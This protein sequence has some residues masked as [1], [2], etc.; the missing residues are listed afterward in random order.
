MKKVCRICNEE[1]DIEYLWI[2]RGTAIC[3][4]CK[5]D[6]TNIQIPLTKTQR[7]RYKQLL[8]NYIK[9]DTIS[10]D[11]P[12]FIM[13]G[14]SPDEL[15]EKIESKFIDNMSWDNYGF[16]GWH[17]D[18]M[19]PLFSAKTEDDLKRLSHYS[20]LQ[21]LWKPTNIKKGFKIIN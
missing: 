12:L 14:C 10:I 2:Q 9:M 20:N 6:Q 16:N 17:I 7:H 11:D 21:P 18:H 3:H 4:S 8:R 15:R 5:S 13:F 1:K 19:T